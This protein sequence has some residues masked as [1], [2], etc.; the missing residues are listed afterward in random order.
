MW[1]YIF[2]DDFLNLMSNSI[3]SSEHH[4]NFLWN[5][6]MWFHHELAKIGDQQYKVFWSQEIVRKNTGY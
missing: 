6:K 1:N 2:F 3:Y 5:L 4:S